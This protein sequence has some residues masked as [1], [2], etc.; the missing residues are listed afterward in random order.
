MRR[1]AQQVFFLELILNLVILS[2]AMGIA[3]VIFLN[4]AKIDAQ[5]K[6]IQRLTSLMINLSEEYRNPYLEGVLDQRITFDVKGFESKD[7]V[8][9]VLDIDST[10]DPGGFRSVDLELS[11]IDGVSIA[12]WTVQVD[13]R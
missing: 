4:A 11:D 6:A 7:N 1:N 12:S 3:L 5:N 8:H 13:W 2:L 10:D 9:Y